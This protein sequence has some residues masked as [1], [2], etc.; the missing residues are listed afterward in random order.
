MESI[1]FLFT[2]FLFFL[3]CVHLWK[4]NKSLR[5]KQEKLLHEITEFK[6]EKKYLLSKKINQDIVSIHRLDEGDIPKSTSRENFQKMQMVLEKSNLSREAYNEGN[7]I[8][9]EVKQMGEVSKQK[10]EQEPILEI[11]KKN[12]IR[13]EEEL[14]SS[15]GVIDKKA[16]GGEINLNEFVRQSTNT[17]KK[18]NRENR[19]FLKDLSKRLEEEVKPQTIELTD[20]EKDQE[21]HAIIS[22][23]E[24]LSS[25]DRV[26]LIEEEDN[27]RLL[28]DLK[29]FREYLGK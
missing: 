27:K 9:T 18:E 25:K 23:Q 5:E 10:L 21:E 16:V 12:W 1:F 8:K 13:G 17:K 4:E 2:T 28:D 26:D 20:Y 7:G 3:F 19:E 29:K 24:L 11:P 6:Q 14:R 15:C 22:Y